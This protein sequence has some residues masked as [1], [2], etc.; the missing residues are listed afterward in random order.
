M[1]RHFARAVA[2]QSLYEWDFRGAG[3]PLAILKRN[4]HDLDTKVD[5]DFS[6]RLIKLFTSHQ[7]E[8]DGLITKAAPE[9]PFGQIAL[10]DR[11]VLRVATAELLYDETV[12][13]KVAINE[14]VELAK[15][16]GSATS[17]R[18]VNGVIGTIYR[19]S[20]RYK[21]EGGDKDHD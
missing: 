9:W 16:Y 18:F 4:C 11:N 6:S 14:A 21:T 3:D 5:L 7:D 2:M 13:P 1:N 12:P 8:I 19:Q 10:L 15:T 20:K 17:S